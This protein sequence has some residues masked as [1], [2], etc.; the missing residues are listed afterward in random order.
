MILSLE[1]KDFLPAR[2]IVEE[3]VPG[4]DLP[5]GVRNM[6]SN[7]ISYVHIA[8]RDIDAVSGMNFDMTGAIAL[9]SDMEKKA[10][11]LTKMKIGYFDRIR[12]EVRSMTEATSYPIEGSGRNIEN[13][14]ILELYLKQILD[15]VSGAEGPVGDA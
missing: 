14:R 10:V 1:I 8:C 7:L 2:D 13:G 6:I 3:I 4:L 9:N 5:D 12:E 15:R 11:E